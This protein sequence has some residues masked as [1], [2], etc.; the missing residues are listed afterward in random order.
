[1]I[2]TTPC[3]LARLAVLKLAFIY[4]LRK[5]LKHPKQILL[6]SFIYRTLLRI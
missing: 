4:F 6:I 2:T 3:D 5:K 1:V